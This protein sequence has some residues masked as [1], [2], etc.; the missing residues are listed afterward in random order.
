MLKV[1]NKARYQGIILDPLLSFKE[2]VAHICN[3]TV[4]KIKLLGRIL[5]FIAKL[6]NLMLYKTL[7]LPIFDYCDFV[8][9]SL[10]PRDTMTLQKL[11]NM[12]LENVF[13]LHK[14]C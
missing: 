12:A 14:L 7:T 3:K 11:Q 5:G 6:M 9:D 8:W 1:V 4:G 2:H 10:S 13:H